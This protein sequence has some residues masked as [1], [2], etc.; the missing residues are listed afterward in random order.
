MKT[1]ADLRRMM[2]A[3]L[4]VIGSTDTPSSEQASMADLW[5]DGARALLAEEG[6]C[7]WDADAVP[8]AV[9]LPFVIYT[10]GL[11]CSAFGKNGKG[12]DA[13]VPGA[14]KQLRKIRAKAQI[15][16]VPGEY[17]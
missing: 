4:K 16:E 6:L 10:A 2:L 8:D 9:T 17:S 14:E 15:D 7:W 12:Y 13:M 3:H 11:C 1:K 5:M